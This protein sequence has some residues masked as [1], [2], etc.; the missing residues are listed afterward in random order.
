MRLPATVN[1]DHCG[2]VDATEAD[3][4]AEV[5]AEGAWICNACHLCNTTYHRA[6]GFVTVLGYHRDLVVGYE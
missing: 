1:C 3:R 5:G 2:Y 4:L 6:G